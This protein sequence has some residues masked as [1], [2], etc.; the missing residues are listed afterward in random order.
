MAR[1]KVAPGL[2]SPGGSRVPSAAHPG[3]RDKLPTRPPAY[4]SPLA[5]LTTPLPPLRFGAGTCRA[6]AGGLENVRKHAV[7]F[8]LS[9]RPNPPAGQ[10]PGGCT[11]SLGVPPTHPCPAEGSQTSTSEGHPGKDRTQARDQAVVPWTGGA[12]EVVWPTWGRGGCSQPRRSKVTG[13][14]QGHNHTLYCSV[15]AAVGS[16]GLRAPR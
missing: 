15:T 9:F 2:S 12:P 14:T 6:K 8:P 11:R 5:A 16:A 4:N 1:P 7:L 3:P 10:G 13:C